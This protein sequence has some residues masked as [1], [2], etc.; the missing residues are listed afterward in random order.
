MLLHCTN[1]QYQHIVCIYKLTPHSSIKTGPYCPTLRYIASTNMNTINIR[2]DNTAV[3]LSLT[4]YRQRNNK[5][6]LVPKRTVSLH[7]LR[8]GVNS[9]L[10]TRPGVA[11]F[12]PPG[13][14]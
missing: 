6:R 14:S 8:R 7:H 4:Q 2:K 12:S 9:Q 10:K 5:G 1:C 13:D 11:A 3:D